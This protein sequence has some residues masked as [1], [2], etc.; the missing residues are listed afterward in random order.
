MRRL[1]R[2]LSIDCLESRIALSGVTPALVS[3][4][5][6]AP[7]GTLYGSFANVGGIGSG[8]VDAG[9]THNY[10][11][12]GYLP[13]L[14][15][16]SIAGTIQGTGNIS[17]GNAGGTFI[18]TG[19]LGTFSLELIGPPQ[20]SF[21]PLPTTYQFHST[22]G[23]GAYSQLQLFGQINLA[24]QPSTR[25]F[26]FAFQTV[27]LD[28]NLHGSSAGVFSS[29]L[30][31]PDVGATYNFSGTADLALFGHCSVFGSLHAVGSV[32]SGQATGTIWVTNGL[33]S[34]KLSV[35]GPIQSSFSS[36]P[37]TFQYQIVGATGIYKGYTARG[38]INLTLNS[39]VNGSSL[40]NQ[41]GP[42]SL[43]LQTRKYN[44]TFATS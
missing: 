39:S 32:S 21:A 37:S 33:G 3:V 6:A 36:L 15:G 7:Y 23:T 38:I 29:I 2:P 34:L 27:N 5:S 9:I 16:V 1:R 28:R 30:T 41:I 13:A 17:N 35:T 20:G 25:T 11:G 10:H 43:L 14:G 19:P 44:L 42:N 12:A 8:H 18:L 26:S 4:Q 31:N 24:E 22:G 40:A